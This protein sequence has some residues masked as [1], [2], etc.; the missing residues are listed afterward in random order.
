LSLLCAVLAI[1][2]SAFG[3]VG[4]ACAVAGV[5]F[6][7][8]VADYAFTARVLRIDFS[9]FV[10]A[11]WRPVTA[12]LA[13]CGAVWLL[14]SQLEPAADAVAHAWSLAWS[15]LLGAVVYAGCLWALWVM[16]G[17]RDGAEQRLL[18]LATRYLDRRSR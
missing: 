9:R 15:T 12:A 1:V 10:A 16:G 14:R 6:L 18:A 8:L 17:R 13:M 4:I 3:I 7:I 2:P 5:G 11:V